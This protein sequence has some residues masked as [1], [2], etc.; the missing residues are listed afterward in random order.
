MWRGNRWNEP[1]LI[2]RKQ[3]LKKIIEGTDVRYNADLAGSVDAII[4]SVKAA[5]LEGV[6]AK[7]GDSFYRAGTRVTSW[8]KFKLSKAQEFVIGGYKPDAGSF[9]SI[10]VGYYEGKELLFAGKVRQGFNPPSRARL[11]AQ[12]R[13]LLTGRCPV[14]NL[15]TSK[16]SHFGEGITKEEMVILCWLRPKLVAQV[17]F[18]EWT[19]YGLL[20]HATFEGLLDDKEPRAVVRAI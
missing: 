4:D 13:P 7:R 15:P 14:A 9:Q 3:K 19:N 6:V 17:S 2:E 1:S 20:R 5:G 16:R 18:T 10:L 8:L 12:M 11:L